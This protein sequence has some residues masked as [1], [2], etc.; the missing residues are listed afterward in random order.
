MSLPKCSSCG[1]T[2][3]GERNIFDELG[4]TICLGCAVGW[5]P[6]TKQVAR[7]QS[8]ARKGPATW[9]IEPNDKR[10]IEP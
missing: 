3:W 9:P 8:I 10:A 4:Y 2:W 1:V 7:D 5:T 6:K